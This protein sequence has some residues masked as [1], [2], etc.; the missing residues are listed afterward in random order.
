[1]DGPADGSRPSAGPHRRL[2][3]FEATRPPAAADLPGMKSMSKNVLLTLGACLLLAACASGKAQEARTGIKTT[4]QEAY[5]AAEDQEQLEQQL[6][7]RRGAIRASNAR[8][9]RALQALYEGHGFA[10]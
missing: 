9:Q 2:L 1:M 6:T 7:E 5:D 8:T 10:W 3:S 4:Q